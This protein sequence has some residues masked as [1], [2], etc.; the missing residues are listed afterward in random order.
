MALQ[1]VIAIIE[2]FERCVPVSFWKEG[3][4]I[5]PELPQEVRDVLE[6]AYGKQPEDLIPH[7][8]GSKL[9]YSLEPQDHPSAWIE[10][11]ARAVVA[12]S[13]RHQALFG[14]VWGGELTVWPHMVVELAV[15]NLLGDDEEPEWVLH[16]GGRWLRLAD[17]QLE[18]ILARL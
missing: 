3:D 14:D 8:Y 4:R 13:L 16:G 12:A 11:H 10:A 1:D 5:V 2:E 6:T 15:R 9:W 17:R 18:R 7:P